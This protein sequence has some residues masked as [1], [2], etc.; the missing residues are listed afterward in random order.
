MTKAKAKKA[1]PKETATI[2]YHKSGGHS[3]EIAVPVKP[4]H[5]EKLINEAEKA[6]A[7]VEHVRSQVKKLPHA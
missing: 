5:G 4:G 2:H 3:V 6:G 1:P 7:D